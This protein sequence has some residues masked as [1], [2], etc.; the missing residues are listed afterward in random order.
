MALG[1]L[2]PALMY[3]GD[4][5][6]YFRAAETDVFYTSLIEFMRDKP[7]FQLHI[8]AALGPI[9]APFYVLGFIGVAATLR[10]PTFLRLSFVGLL[11]FSICLGSAYHAGFPHMVYSTPSGTGTEDFFFKQLPAEQAAYFMAL[12][13]GY[14]APAALAW[15]GLSILVVLGKTHLPRWFIVFSPVVW[16]W[17]GEPLHHL[18]PPLNVALAGG[19]FNLQYL[20]MFTAVLVWAAVR[21]TPSATTQAK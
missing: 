3:V 5:L 13:Y 7:A 10:G 9:S 15:V 17:L 6:M 21:S 4:L 18:S 14:L 1:L 11:V 20:P 8:G 19:W 16:Y 2:G 12:L